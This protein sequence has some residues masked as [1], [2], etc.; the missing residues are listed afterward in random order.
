MSRAH[1]EI[2]HQIRRLGA[3][4]D[5]I[6]ESE[7]DEQD[8][9]ELCRVRHGLHAIPRLSTV[10]EEE[11]YPSL[12]NHAN[13]LSAPYGGRPVQPYDGSVCAPSSQSVV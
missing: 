6:G 7:P 11:S 12:G 9:D 2:A 3:L 8:I 1:V 13:T 4:I 5:D 10:Q